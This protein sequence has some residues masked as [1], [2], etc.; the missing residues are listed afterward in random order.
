[1]KPSIENQAISRAYRMGQARNVLVYRL[2]CENSVDSHMMN[3]LYA[4]QSEFDFYADK[5][6]SGEASLAL[7]ESGIQEIIALETKRLGL[8]D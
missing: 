6:K 5:S 4:K 3:R 1:M 2:L 7:S 8:E